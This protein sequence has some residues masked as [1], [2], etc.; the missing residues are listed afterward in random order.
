LRWRWLNDGA[1]WQLLGCDRVTEAVALASETGCKHGLGKCALCVSDWFRR[2]AAQRFDPDRQQPPYIATTDRTC[3]RGD[4]RFERPVRWSVARM[5]DA[6]R[7][8][9]VAGPSWLLPRPGC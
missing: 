3:S 9:I 1:I 4:V 6:I 2:V 8:I 7:H 5:A